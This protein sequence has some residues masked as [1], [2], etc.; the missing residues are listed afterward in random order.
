[1]RIASSST[2]TTRTTTTRT[3]DNKFSGRIVALLEKITSSL[4][5]RLRRYVV[6]LS[7]FQYQ[8]VQSDRH[9]NIFA[10]QTETSGEDIRQT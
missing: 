6:R 4:F 8:F 3:N 9:Q 10:K 2:T 1:M 7:N 5:N